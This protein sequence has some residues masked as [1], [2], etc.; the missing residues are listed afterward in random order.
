[1]QLRRS[2]GA[3]RGGFGDRVA[4]RLVGAGQGEEVACRVGILRQPPQRV[5]THRVDGAERVGER[6][7]E[8]GGRA[9]HAHLLVGRVG[10]AAEVTVPIQGQRRLLAV[11]GD[12]GGR[13]G[14]AALDRGDVAV[15]VRD[16]A[17]SAGTVVAEL[18]ESD[19]GPRVEGAELLAVRVEDV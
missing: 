3:V 10:D 4:Q 12:D 9:H 11:R 13:R 1:D 2:G 17:Q 7:E 6:L 8:A 18:V 16:G 15:L 19:A 5:V 14:A